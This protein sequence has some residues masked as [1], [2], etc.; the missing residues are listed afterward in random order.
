M[1]AYLLRIGLSIEAVH[2]FDVHDDCKFNDC[3]EG[4]KEKERQNNLHIRGNSQNSE[5]WTRK[6]EKEKGRPHEE[7][8][9][10]GNEV[11]SLLIGYYIY[12]PEAVRMNDVLI[13]V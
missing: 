6:R 10:T 13:N 7:C 1:S 3:E 8:T 12:C 2:K 5:R 4:D 9:N 11:Y